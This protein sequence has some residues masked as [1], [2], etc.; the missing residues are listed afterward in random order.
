MPANSENKQIVDKMT[1]PNKGRPTDIG[2][3]MLVVPVRDNSDSQAYKPAA[4]SS[5]Q[6]AD[7]TPPLFVLG[8]SYFSPSSDEDI[9]TSD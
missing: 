6:P 5:A 7:C 1:R 4:K 8:Y 9:S 3:T 2:T